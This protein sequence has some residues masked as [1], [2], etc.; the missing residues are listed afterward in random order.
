[1]GGEVRAAG[2]GEA[3]MMDKQEWIGR[4][5]ARLRQRGGLNA[6]QAIA[7][8]EAAFAGL[9]YTAD[10]LAESPEDSADEAMSIWQD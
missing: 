3:L 7:R 5:A 10:D 9:A 4:C 6:A 8:A 1:M 2:S